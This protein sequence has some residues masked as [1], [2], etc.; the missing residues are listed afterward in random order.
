[1]NNDYYEFKDKVNKFFR[2][3]R[4]KGYFAKQKFMCCNGCG[5]AN[6][7]EEFKNKYVFYHAQEYWRL[8]ETKKR[9]HL[10]PSLHLNWDGDGTEIARIARGLELKTNWDG[11]PETKIELI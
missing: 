10:T 5:T 11:S 2:E 6:I 7:P 1:M 4:K 3:L 9:T 8:E